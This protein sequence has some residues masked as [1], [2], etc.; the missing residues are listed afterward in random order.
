MSPKLSVT[1]QGALFVF[2]SAF[3]YA[4]LPIFTKL[5]FKY[6]LSPSEAIFYRYLFAFIILSVYLLYKKESILIPSAKVLGQGLFLL[7]GSIFYFYALQHIAASTG[8]IIFFTHPIIV[9]VLAVLI[10]KE[11][12]NLSLAAGLLLE[13]GRASCRERV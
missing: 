5:A 6:G 1:A 13:I 7:G 10:Y 9:A 4:T 2:I 12:I 8:S 11:K 3:M